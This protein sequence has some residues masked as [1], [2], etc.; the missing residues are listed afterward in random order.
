M[1]ALERLQRA[2]P[3]PDSER[4]LAAEGAMNAFVRSARHRRSAMDTTPRE[5]T[6]ALYEAIEQPVRDGVGAP[7]VTKGR[8]LRVAIAAAV[9]ALVGVAGLMWLSGSDEALPF[10]AQPPA[11]LDFYEDAFNRGDVD[12]LVGLFTDDAV[13]QGYSL[14]DTL[15]TGGEEIRVFF[16]AETDR[17]STI[18][19]SNVAATAN[20][21][22][23]DVEWVSQDFA[24]VTWPGNM[25]TFVDGKISRWDWAPPIFGAE[26]YSSSLERIPTLTSGAPRRA[27]SAV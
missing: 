20:S 7:G 27:A 10:G 1:S 25:V 16:T 22:T 5:E 26:G 9:V 8:G 14:G 17:G 11:V 4:L 3:V 18:S 15:V 19:V 6:V 2:N 21:A 13:I 23:V 12:A 24:G